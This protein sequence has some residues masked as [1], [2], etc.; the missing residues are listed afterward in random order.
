MF[1]EYREILRRAPLGHTSHFL[2][3]SEQQTP[4]MLL[5]DWAGVPTPN[6]TDLVWNFT[7]HSNLKAADLPHF[8]RTA[9]IYSLMPCPR[10][11][12]SSACTLITFFHQ[13]AEGWVG[14]G[15]QSECPKITRGNTVK[16]GSVSLEGAPRWLTCH[17]T[18][19]IS[20]YL[21]LS[22]CRCWW[23][24]EIRHDLTL[25]QLTVSLGR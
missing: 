8:G 11:H 17:S 6:F 15:T 9:K 10:Y 14:G 16:E 24:I 5:L 18:K 20:K 23:R 7:S 22:L 1:R 4:L 2:E 13:R 12:E 3:Q 21:L 25:R 19:A